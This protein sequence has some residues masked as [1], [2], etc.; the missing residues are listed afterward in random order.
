VNVELVTANSQRLLQ[1]LSNV[2]CVT[3]TAVSS[4][5][6][7]V[8]DFYDIPPPSASRSEILSTVP[9][10]KTLSTESAQDKS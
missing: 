2:G 7:E 5:K 9:M 6:P 3:C 10:A 8:L 1:P 4:M